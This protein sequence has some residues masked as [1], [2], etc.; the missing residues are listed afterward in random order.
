V[1]GGCI[2]KEKKEWDEQQKGYKPASEEGEGSKEALLQGR[3]S[4]AHAFLKCERGENG[5]APYL[6]TAR[7]REREKSTQP[8]GIS[9]GTEGVRGISQYLQRGGRLTS[10]AGV[11]REKLKSPRGLPA[12][13]RNN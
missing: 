4:W 10:G 1:C 9:Y 3:I 7:H 5:E 2:E 8:G 12:C 11:F 6:S 13:R